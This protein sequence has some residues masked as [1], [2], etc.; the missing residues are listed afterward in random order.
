MYRTKYC[1]EVTTED[2]DK[3]IKLAG[4]VEQGKEGEEIKKEDLEKMEKFNAEEQKNFKEKV[5][6]RDEACT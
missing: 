4:W 6:R 1:G 3:E 5:S 2:I